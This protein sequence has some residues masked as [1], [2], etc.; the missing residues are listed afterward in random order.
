MDPAGGVY[1]RLHG[2]HRFAGRLPDEC[3]RAA[4]RE[5]CGQLVRRPLLRFDGSNDEDDGR[6][7]QKRRGI[8]NDPEQSSISLF[9][10]WGEKHFKHRY[11]PSHRSRKA[12]PWKASVQSS[13]G[14]W[15]HSVSR[16]IDGEGK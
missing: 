14:T 7:Q 2:D 10:D 9:R 11:H 1:V 4:L 3:A 12:E 6:G 15:H 16:L 8:P 13:P 5:N